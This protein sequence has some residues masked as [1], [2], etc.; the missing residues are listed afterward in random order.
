MS[1]PAVLLAA[2][3]GKR[4]G[5]P[6]ALLDLEG[7]PML[8]LVAR[9][10]RGAGFTP[11]IAAVHPS[12]LERVR[13][14][15]SGLDTVV[16]NPDPS[17]GPLASL[18]IAMRSLPANAQGILMV[19]VD[20]ALVQPDTYA[21]LAEAVRRDPGRLWRPVHGG[22][23]GHPVWFPQDLLSALERAPLD[24][25]ARAVVYANQGRWGDVEVDDPWILRDIDHPQ[26]LADAREA[27]RGHPE[28]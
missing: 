15:I 4:I 12:L 18:H 20:F 28:H 6:K 19:K 26:D 14:E 3:E 1:F 9:R 8:S 22:R 21:A 27:I 25:G 23:H 2:G 5:G 7:E 17:T 24:R 13:R 10:C 16:E 11:L